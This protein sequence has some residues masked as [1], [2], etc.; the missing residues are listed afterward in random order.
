MGIRP[1]DYDPHKS[2]AFL[3][4]LANPSDRKLRLFMIECERRAADVCGT[5]ELHPLL[6]V[7][8]AHVDGKV[9]SAELFAAY[10]NA[11]PNGKSTLK[12]LATSRPHTVAQNFASISADRV[13]SVIAPRRYPD[14]S[15]GRPDYWVGRCVVMREEDEIQLTWLL[16]MFDG[17]VELRSFPDSWRS[18][19]AVALARTAY[20]TRNFTLLPI[21]ADA[22]EEAGCDHTDVLTHCRDPQQVHVRGCWVV[23]G[24]LGKS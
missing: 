8:T 12:S 10:E 19:S 11:D 22:L 15:F 21:L 20:D 3:A 24:V 2:L 5:P 9:S 17:P 1:A 18:E 13:V 7:F 23:D 16:D 6:E 4:R 14:V